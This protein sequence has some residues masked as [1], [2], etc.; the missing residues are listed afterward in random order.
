MD[1][2][3]RVRLLWREISGD[4]RQT[5]IPRLAP[6]SYPL[7]VRFM[8]TAGWGVYHAASHM[9]VRAFMKRDEAIRFMF[10]IE[11]MTDWTEA[12]SGLIVKNPGLIAQ[13]HKTAL[14]VR[15]R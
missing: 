13:L 15:G 9:H 11:N 3:T 5:F 4:K 6:D 12:P 7:Y 1:E 10:A 2:I 14:E 8:Q